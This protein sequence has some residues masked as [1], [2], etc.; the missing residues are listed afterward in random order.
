MREGN[1]EV[2]GKEYQ[3]LAIKDKTVLDI[4]CTA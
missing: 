2:L 1:G 4:Y 3:V